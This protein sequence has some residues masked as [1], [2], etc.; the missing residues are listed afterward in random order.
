MAT[1]VG[2]AWQ[3]VS[4]AALSATTGITGSVDVASFTSGSSGSV[5]GTN[6]PYIQLLACQ[7][8]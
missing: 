4:G 1:G 5:A 8:S 6:A 2:G 3:N 7:K